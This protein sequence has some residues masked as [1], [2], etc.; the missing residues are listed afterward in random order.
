VI[1][2]PT[3]PVTT[4]PWSQVYLAEM[5]GKPLANYYRW[6]A[7]TYLVTL[8]TNP[9]ISLPCGTD[10]AGMP[11]GLQVIGAFRGD[12]RLLDIAQSLETR[13]ERD[14]ARRRVR[15]DLAKLAQPVPELK[16]IVTAAPGV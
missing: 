14:A 4:F 2:S 11:F 6:L 15:P 1:V 7:L 10:Y 5:N 9:A 12:A 16:S 8:A 13:W 3:T